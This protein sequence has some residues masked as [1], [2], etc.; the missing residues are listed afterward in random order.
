MQDPDHHQKVVAGE[1]ID[2]EIV[3]TL[4]RPCTQSLKVRILKMLRSTSVGHLHDSINGIVH[5]IQKSVGNFINAQFQIVLV[6]TE[7]VAP[8]CFLDESFQN[9]FTC[10][11]LFQQL[12]RICP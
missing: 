7:N 3:K 2:P 9:S 8:S 12:G 6:L 10:S 1:I 5:G 11:V 4:D